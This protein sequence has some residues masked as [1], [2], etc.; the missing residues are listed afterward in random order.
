[1]ECRTRYTLI[2]LERRGLTALSCQLAHRKPNSLVCYA[3][4][5]RTY[6]VYSTRCTTHMCVHTYFTPTQR[7]VCASRHKHRSATSAILYVWTFKVF[8]F[9]SAIA[10][11]NTTC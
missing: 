6:A 10:M 8:V 3:P 7:L 9:Y 2:P 4:S 1:M 11:L 5:L